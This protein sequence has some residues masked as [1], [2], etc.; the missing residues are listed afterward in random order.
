MS[1]THWKQ[2]INPDYFGAYAL[3]DG[4][5]LTVKIESVRREIVTSTGGK[6]EE[7]TVVHLVKNKPLI[8]NRTN[9]K[10]I[11]KLYW[12]YIEDWVG[13]LITLHASTTKLAG[14][15]VECVRIRP[16][17]SVSKKTISDERL[18]GAIESVKSGTW[19]AEKL[20]SQ[21][22]LTPEQLATFNDAIKPE[23]KGAA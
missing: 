23:I 2:L 14:E 16:Q 17:V 22:E 9:A 21:F 1:K 7:C 8:L 10:S 19:T 6:K 12:P 3:P 15:T 4:Q 5:D 13:Q 20:L 18:K 11:T